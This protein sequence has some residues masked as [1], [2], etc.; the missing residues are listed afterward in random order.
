MNVDGT[1]LTDLTGGDGYND[2]HPSWSPD[3]SKIAFDSV[4]DGVSGIFTMRPDGSDVTRITSS[5]NACGA[6]HSGP[7]WSPDG[8][9]LAFT[10]GADD[11]Q[12]PYAN[13][14]VVITNAD[15]T[16]AV[17]KGSDG[18]RHGRRTALRSPWL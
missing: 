18:R 3:G 6:V 10:T 11:S 4:R 13:A 5:C 14:Q 8:R 2:R 17:A 15:G 12:W 16:N 1:G 9:K 7:D